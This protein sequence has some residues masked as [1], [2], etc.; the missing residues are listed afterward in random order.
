MV[1]CGLNSGAQQQLF[2]GHRADG[3]GHDDHRSCWLC[4]AASDHWLFYAK[5]GGGWIQ[6]QA[7]LADVATGAS[8]STT[9]INGGWAAGVGME[10]AF[11][12]SWTLKVEYQ[13]LGLNRF[14]VSSSSVADTSKVNNA[15]VQM[16]T[17][18]IN[19]LFHWSPPASIV[20]R[21]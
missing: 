5:G 16:A 3:L 17:V 19:Y 12:P 13:Y 4:S 8:T 21:Y 15:N 20:A 11:L 6:S 14:T 1:Y 9:K 18:G 7:T 2:A 10:W